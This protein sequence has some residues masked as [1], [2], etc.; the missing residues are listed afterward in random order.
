MPTDTTADLVDRLTFRWD[1]QRDALTALISG[2]ARG[3]AKRA[4]ATVGVNDQDLL[5]HADALAVAFAEE[6][7][8]ELVGMRVN[9]DGSVT[10]N[11]EAEWSISGATRDMLRSVVAD[12]VAEGWS[13]DHLRQAILDD[14][15]FSD[16]RAKTIARTEIAFA[17]EAGNV[18]GWKASNQVE[19]VRWLLGSE[20]GEPD[21][22]DD[23]A[24]DDAVPLGEE[25]SSGD[26]QPPAHPNCVCALVAV[27]KEDLET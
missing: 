21:E 2:V 22:C 23:N 1:D 13:A 27:L 18:A 9:E 11:P 24:D 10:P 3:A 7:G 26:S 19:A 20:H 8:A 15:A 12:A 25:F 17:H 5:D 14:H 6:R 16:D 4:I